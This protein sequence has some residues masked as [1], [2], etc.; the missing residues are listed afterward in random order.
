MKRIC[1]VPVVFVFVLMCGI[2]SVPAQVPEW[3][4]PEVTDISTEAP[5]A[6]AILYQDRAAAL[7][8][9]PAR[10]ANYRSL[11]GNWKFKWVKNPFEAPAGFEKTEYDAAGWDN[12]PVP[13]NWQVVAQNEN[14]PYDKPFFTN[15][16]HPFKADP[17]HVPHDNNPVGL[18]R[19]TFTVPAA[20]DGRPAFIH[21]AGVQSA[22]FLWVNGQKVGY[23]EDAFTPAEFEITRY[24][25]PGSNV[26]AAEVI[27]HSDGSYL[28]DQ[29]YW[30]LAGIFRDVFLWSSPAVHIRDFQVLT[31]LDDQYRDAILELTVKVKN[32]GQKSSQGP[33]VMAELLDAAG[34][35]ILNER[36]M[37]ADQLAGGNEVTLNATPTV[38]NPAKWTAETPSLYTLVLSLVE[39]GKA[40]EV[41]SARIGFREVVI[42]GGQLLV[43][44]VPITVKGVNRHEFDPDHGRVVS[45][46]SMIQDILLMKRHNINAVRT[47]HY[48][49]NPLWYDLCDEYGLWVMDEA[50]IESHELWE[51]GVYLTEK[52]EWRKAFVD[53]GV[54]MVERDKNHP[55]IIFWSMGNETGWGTNF[56]A[57][58]AQMKKIDPSRPIHYES[59]N[60]AYAPTLSR[61]DIISTMY[62]STRHI[63]ELM[64]KD[65]TRPVII[66]EYAHSMGN[67]V[68]NFKDYWDLYDK[69]PRLQGGFTW[70]WVDQ[71]LRIRE[72]DGKVKWNY[73]NYSDGANVND[74]LILA[75]RTAQPELQEVKKVQQY[76]K[77]EAVDAGRGQVKI[78]NS[79]DFRSLD[80][81]ELTWQVIE[82]GQ[83]MQQGKLPAPKLAAGKSEVVSLPVHG[84]KPGT[85][86]LLGVSLRLT[87][88]EK[89]AAAGHEVAWE[90]FELQP[91][92][93]SESRPE[94][95]GEVKLTETGNGFVVT[96]KDFRVGFDQTGALSSYQWNGTELLASALRP[97][98]WRVPTDNDE[99]GGAASFASR[100]R[101]AGLDQLSVKLQEVKGEQVGTGQARV[102]SVLALSGK[103]GTIT[104]RATYSVAPDGAVRLQSDFKS[105]GEWPPLPK[106]GVQLQLPGQF[107]DVEWYG[108][109]PH[110][111]YWDRKTGA[112]V[113]S[114]RA[115]AAD[116][117]FLQVNPQENGNRSDVRWIRL[118]N[119]SGSGMEIRGEGLFNFTVHDY[120]DQ[121]LLDA[122]KTQE[123]VRDGKI[124]LSLD[125]QQTGL[126]GDDSWSP[127]THP[128][129]LLRAKEYSFVLKFKPTNSRK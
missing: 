79:Y 42:R 46:E 119:A 53:R 69:Y 37:T 13:S 80:G 123:I 63:V 29:D 57:M 125:L 49:N 109:G 10:S 52:P 45:R 114:Y 81:L 41:V 76:V 126:G 68:G 17:P 122:K 27:H 116:M 30:R 75:D 11:N 1:S 51:K 61:Y 19:T 14:R 34:K 64:E 36:L 121:A 16:K 70:D 38:P 7:G 55:S 20:W 112:R 120:T 58:Y 28:E 5:H 60:P 124:T 44:G 90:Q 9:D 128:E 48:P 65:P 84:V 67:S 87:A 40:Q 66:C 39:N 78:T 101:Q 104:Y 105:D 102:V 71:A 15:I 100:W 98:L 23:S 6:F 89:W 82:D 72:R 127:R 21:F 25:K 86:A 97:N 96:G 3:E 111:S 115:K 103:R 73:I 117:G 88:N 33:T 18:Y 99:G 12:I 91:A 129:Y 56:D 8:F 94:R 107:A 93:A 62:P 47:S 113:G 92:T 32:Y 110:E 31:N 24:L 54:A 74:G 35:R 85:E 50:N 77:F 22:F 108:R 4:N 95:S 43:N 2:P 106:V 59:R 118:T 26:L 83:V